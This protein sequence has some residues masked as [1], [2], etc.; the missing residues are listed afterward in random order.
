M[1]GAYQQVARSLHAAWRRGAHA[2]ATAVE[3]PPTERGPLSRMAMGHYA[4]AL[5]HQATLEAMAATDAGAA[6]VVASGREVIERSIANLADNMRITG[7]A[8]EA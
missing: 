7:N 5:A 3:L 8:A 1:T 2:A 4:E 6:A